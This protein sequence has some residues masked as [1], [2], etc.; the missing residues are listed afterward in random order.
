MQIGQS[1]EEFL[2][3]QSLRPSLTQCPRCNAVL[4]YPTGTF[5]LLDEER[6]WTIPLAVCPNCD[7]DK[8]GK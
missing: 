8:L 4:L 5:F 7:L 2:T 6:S 3:A 1:I